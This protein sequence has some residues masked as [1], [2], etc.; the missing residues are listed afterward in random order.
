MMTPHKFQ[1]Y[2]ICIFSLLVLSS[3]YEAEDLGY[4][5]IENDNVR[6][7]VSRTEA[8]EINQSYW[9]YFIWYRLDSSNMTEDMI[10]NIRGVVLRSSNDEFYYD[11][12]SIS[13]EFRIRELRAEKGSH[14]CV[15]FFFVDR[16]MQL[17]DIVFDT[18]T[19]MTW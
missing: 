7:F 2:L 11:V 4:N 14:Y 9:N 15:D 3:C 10:K 17:T 8:Y 12:D 18:C 5:T 19:V 16:N 1:Y 13:Q 6:F